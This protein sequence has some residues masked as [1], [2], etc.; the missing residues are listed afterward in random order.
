MRRGEKEKKGYSWKASPQQTIEVAAISWDYSPSIPM[1]DLPSQICKTGI[2]TYIMVH[3]MLM[4]TKSIVQDSIVIILTNRSR[5]F[6]MIGYPR[7]SS[8]CTYQDSQLYPTQGKHSQSYTFNKSFNLRTLFQCFSNSLFFHWLLCRKIAWW[9]LLL[10]Q[11]HKIW[12]SH[13]D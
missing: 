13:L 7:L 5:L 11:D 2:L 10:A 4:Y 3:R 9:R 12:G 8:L 1:T 6:E